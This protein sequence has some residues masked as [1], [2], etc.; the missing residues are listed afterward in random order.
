[1]VL[2]FI[3]ENIIMPNVTLYH[4]PRCSK[5]RQTLELLKAHQICPTIREYLKQPPTPAELSDILSKLD[6]TAAQLL[7]KKEG[8]YQEKH[9]DNPNLSEGDLIHAMVTNPILIERPIVIT[10]QHARIG[11]PPENILEI[12]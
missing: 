7:R 5:S 8:L 3:E 9:L 4:N 1:M 12:L 2:L 6:M 10:D 11:R